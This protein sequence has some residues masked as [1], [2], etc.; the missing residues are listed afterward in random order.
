MLTFMTMNLVIVSNLLQSHY[1]LYVI[2][3][4]DIPSMNFAVYGILS[5]SYYY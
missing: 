5:H 4:I 2:D 3:Y 1:S